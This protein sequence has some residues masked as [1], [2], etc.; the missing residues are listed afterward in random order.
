MITPDQIV[1]KAERL[2]PQL[3]S[4]WLRGASGQFFPHRIPA[5]L[6]PDSDVAVA[7]RDVQA[8][9]DRSKAVRGFGYSIRWEPRHSRTLG[10]NDFPVAVLV[11]TLDDLL[12][13]IGRQAEFRRL[14]EAVGI[15]R[16]KQ[17]TLND[18]LL[19]RANWKALL[20]V[21][22]VLDDLLTVVEYFV[23]HPRPDC[24][25]RELP[26]AISTK[27]IEKHRRILATWFDRVLSPQAIDA[28]FSWDQFEPRYGLRYVRPHF[29]L[30]LLD[31]E[32]QLELG[33]LTDELSMPAETIARLPIKSTRVLI[34]ENKLNLLTLPP[35]QR[36]IAL[37]GVG[38]AVTQ[39]GDIGWLDEA[40]IYYWGDLDVEGFEIMSRLRNRFPRLRSILMDE[41]TYCQF[42][43]WAIEGNAV[44]RDPPAN[45]SRAERET[46][47]NLRRTRHR[48][49]QER[50][51]QTAVVRA[52]EALKHDG[53]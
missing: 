2:Y 23:D 1:K 48:L 26:L 3:I 49:E 45:L 50:I 47:L 9:R 7:I 31:R 10:S 36:T 43:S 35:I 8:L 12:R 37:G 22:D 32:L 39:L 6:K 11:E 40:D 33:L 14:S 13:L 19:E 27:L 44:D 21:A 30:R 51:P 24:F 52:I 42:K 38:N 4:T 34:V 25:A 46:Y 53:V 28:R 5:N 20:D 16:E 41:A 15:L 18:W 17:P 29:L